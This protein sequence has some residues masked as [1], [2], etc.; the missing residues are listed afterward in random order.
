MVALKLRVLEVLK[1][2]WLNP[3]FLQRKYINEGLKKFC[4][5]AKGILLDIGCGN[6]PYL[7]LF[8][9][10]VYCYYG[11]EYPNVQDIKN[12][13]DAIRPDIY[14]SGSNLPFKSNSVDTILCTEVLEHIPDVEEA[15]S[16]FARVL[17][18]KGKVIATVPEVLRHHLEPYDYYRFTKY[19]LQYLFEKN[20]FKVIEIVPRGGNWAVISSILSW[21]VFSF[22]RVR[23]RLFRKTVGIFAVPLCAM[24]QIFGYVL[25][26]LSFIDEY[27]MGHLIVAERI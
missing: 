11:I 20:G 27:N 2:T 25:D 17:K 15:I 6:K 9:K 18:I 1:F 24:V 16:E 12:V 19:G 7:P 3:N 13:P 22:S 26:K 14:S 23:N 8:K 21:Q 4:G 5:H 10:N